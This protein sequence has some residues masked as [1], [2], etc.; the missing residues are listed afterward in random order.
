M[1]T[2][3]TQMKKTFDKPDEV[4][5]L[6]KSRIDII[7]SG[8]QMLMRV[9]FEPGW[10]WS[11]DIGPTVGT[12]RCEARHFGYVLS[13]RCHI[14]LSDRTEYDL[15]PGDIVDLPPGHDGW[16]IGKEPFVAI[17]FLGGEH[18]GMKSEA[19]FSEEGD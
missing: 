7:R 3:L 15:G 8:D 18:Y 2:V 5:S 10:K 17:D 11:K 12:D 14:V 6:S 19:E 4:R 16:V 13:G 9:T 1:S